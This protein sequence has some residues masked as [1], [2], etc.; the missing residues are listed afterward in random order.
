MFSYLLRSVIP[1]LGRIQKELPPQ[2]LSLNSRNCRK[3]SYQI[4]YFDQTEATVRY[5]IL[6]RLCPI[7]GF[8]YKNITMIIRSRILGKTRHRYCEN[9]AVEIERKNTRKLTTAMIC[10]CRFC[11]YPVSSGK[12][13]CGVL[14]KLLMG[15]VQLRVHA[16]T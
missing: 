3:T 8:A 11:S 2:F 5:F 9:K 10:E 15:I 6:H 4:M 16:D 13:K 7:F 1:P 14:Q 12:K